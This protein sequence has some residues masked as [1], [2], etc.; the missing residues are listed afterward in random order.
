MRITF[1]DYYN[2][3]QNITLIYNN[4]RSD[5]NEGEW[6]RFMLQ[7]L[8]GRSQQDIQQF[9]LNSQQKPQLTTSITIPK[10]DETLTK[11]IDKYNVAQQRRKNPLYLLQPLIPT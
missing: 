2:E 5:Q 11:L 6:S 3:Q 7:L 1:I 9:F 4:T 10:N 8:I